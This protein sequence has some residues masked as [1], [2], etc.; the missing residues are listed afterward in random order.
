M[1]IGKSAAQF[2]IHFPEGIEAPEHMVRTAGTVHGDIRRC[3]F[4][5][6]ILAPLIPYNFEPAAKQRRA[7]LGHGSPPER[8]VI[9]PVAN[10]QV[11]MIKKIWPI[12]RPFTDMPELPR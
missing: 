1:N 11:A 8:S 9:I 2:P 12:V 5:H 4:L 6:Q 3:D 10:S 7:T